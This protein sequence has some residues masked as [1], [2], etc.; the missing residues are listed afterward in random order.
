MLVCL[1]AAVVIVAGLTLIFHPPRVTP[2]PPDP[3]DSWPDGGLLPG[4]DVKHA[5]F[6]IWN[7]KPKWASGFL[8]LTNWR[9]VW[10]PARFWGMPGTIQDALTI[11]LT[12][13]E[14]AYVKRSRL[15]V[16]TADEDSVFF[17]TISCL[18]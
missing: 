18:L 10:A 3:G 15:H 16:V 2:V 11:R 1:A 14:D 6:A 5:S 9:L 17:S 13:I 12:H 8:Y 7:A 4:E